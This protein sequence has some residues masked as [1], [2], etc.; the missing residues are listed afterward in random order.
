MT[1]ASDLLQHHIQ[2]LVDDNTRWQTLIA[3]DIVW[4]LAYAPSLG[5]PARLAGREAVVAHATWFVGAVEHFRFFDL[6]VY[7]LAIRKAQSPKSK[8][9]DSSNLR[10]VPTARIMCCSCVLLAARSRSCA[11]ISTPCERPRRWTRQF[12]ISNPEGKAAMGNSKNRGPKY[13]TFQGL[14]PRL[15]L[16]RTAR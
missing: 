2:T 12:L 1:V 14:G 10:G 6:R 15:T 16:H 11:N 5:H 8:G 13:P 9:K 7:A 3:D 4:E